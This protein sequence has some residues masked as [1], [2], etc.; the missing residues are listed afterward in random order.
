MGILNVGPAAGIGL[1]GYFRALNAAF[2]GEPRLRSEGPKDDPHP[3]DVLRGYLAAETVGLLGFSSRDAWSSLIAGE[4]N[5]DVKTIVLAGARVSRELARQSAGIVAQTL[6]RYRA[7]ALENHALGEIQDWRDAEEEIVLMLRAALRA[8]AEL[9]PTRSQI[10]AAHV[11]SAAVTEALA[12]GSEVHVVFD[13]MV[14][15]LDKLHGQNPS[16]GP[17]ILPY[18]GNICRKVGFR[19]HPLGPGLR[20]AVR[21]MG[22]RK[23]LSPANRGGVSHKYHRHSNL[24]SRARSRVRLR[25]DPL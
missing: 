13:R 10:Y 21:S 22:K 2:T 24:R 11:V 3:A 4:T 25:T 1:I 9:P 23:G 5:A 20:R 6:V 8:S 16:T 17:L 18:R 14:A 12:D 7:G 15:L 19:F